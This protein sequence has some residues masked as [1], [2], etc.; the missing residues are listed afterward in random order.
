MLPAA[1]IAIRW[2]R[3]LLL[4]LV[5]FGMAYAA[6]QLALVGALSGDLG[7][8]ALLRWLVLAAP[9]LGCHPTVLFARCSQRRQWRDGP[10]EGY[11]L[12]TPSC[13]TISPLNKEGPSARAAD[14]LAACADQRVGADG[15]MSAESDD[16]E[17]LVPASAGSVSECFVR[18]AGLA[19][20]GDACRERD[21]TG[22]R[23]PHGVS[24]SIEGPIARDP[25]PAP[26]LRG[27]C[28]TELAN[29]RAVRI[30]AGLVPD[31]EKTGRQI[32]RL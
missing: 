17:C 31:D 6:A 7:F 1:I 11:D 3:R 19:V 26:E 30:R 8:A 2:R 14:P 5:G 16:A 21:D 25:A 4:L 22:E 29:D 13:P 32:G 9:E 12:H 23:T 18:A 28:W 20:D 15:S 27:E 10:L 24:L